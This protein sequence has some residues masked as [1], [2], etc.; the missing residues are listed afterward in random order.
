MPFPTSAGKPPIFRFLELD[1]EEHPVKAL[2]FPMHPFRIFLLFLTLLSVG[3]RGPVQTITLPADMVF[4]DLASNQPIGT[5][6]LRGNLVLLNLWAAWSPT[7]TK[8]LPLLVELEKEYAPKGLLV[9]GIC[10]D[11]A[12]AA[13]LLVF[14][15]R[16]GIH[17][18][19][20]RPGEKTLDL[21][22]P[23]E[24]VPYT[25]LLDPKGKILARFRGPFKPADLRAALDQ[26]L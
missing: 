19:L 17:Y 2:L 20:V 15:E 7:T 16:H 1:V 5:N 25:L 13:S 3:C 18:P 14:A 11:D 22:D 4:L 9:I 23:L 24:T 26:Y 10:L 12:P 8:E 21:L 6:L